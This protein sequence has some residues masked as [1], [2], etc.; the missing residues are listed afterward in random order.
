MDF[1]DF[2]VIGDRI[3]MRILDQF[4][5]GHGY[6]HNWCLPCPRRLPDL[7]RR[8]SPRR[9]AGA[10]DVYTDQPGVQFYTANWLDQEKGKK[11]AFYHART[12]FCFETQNFLDAVNKLHF[13]SPDREGRKEWMSATGYRFIFMKNNDNDSVPSWLQAKIHSRSAAPMRFCFA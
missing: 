10:M 13:P 5:M 11:G 12:A 9:A 4:V 7:P 8:S 1:T 2:H 3:G 6:D